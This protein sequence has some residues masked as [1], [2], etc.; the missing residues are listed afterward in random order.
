MTV[1]IYKSTD[2][3]A[4]VLYPL[5]AGSL[6]ALLKAVLVD[7]YGSQTGAGWTQEFTNGAGITVL[8]NNPSIANSSGMYLRIDHSA[9]KYVAKLA[10]YKTMSDINTGTNRNPTL[11]QSTD[12][13]Y[14]RLGTSTTSGTI[15]GQIIIADERTFYI[16]ICLDNA[17]QVS[18]YYT[19]AYGAGDFDSYVPSDGNNYFLNS[20]YEDPQTGVNRGYPNQGTYYYQNDTWYGFSAGSNSALQTD[21]ATKIW[22]PTLNSNDVSGSSSN[23]ARPNLYTGLLILHDSYICDKNGFRGKLRGAKNNTGRTSNSFGLIYTPASTDIDTTPMYEMCTYN[24]SNGY[25]N[26]IFIKTDNQ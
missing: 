9:N 17:N 21:S 10:T 14:Q 23:T 16:N 18:G 13:G 4:P 11:G 24:S 15:S 1:K 19:V 22:C 6:N 26:S 2:S 25:Y 7:G 20:G 12:G 3:D 8:R 5:V